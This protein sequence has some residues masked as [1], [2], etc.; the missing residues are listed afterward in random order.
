MCLEQ[1][2]ASS[3]VIRTSQCVKQSVRKDTREWWGLATVWRTNASPKDSTC[4]STPNVLCQNVGPES[5][6]LLIWKGEIRNPY[7]YLFFGHTAQ[8]AGS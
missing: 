7:F 3:S 4:R 5:P 1:T 2:A 6:D 8:H